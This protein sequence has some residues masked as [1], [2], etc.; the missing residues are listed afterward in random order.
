MLILI[1]WLATFDPS[2]NVTH[3]LRFEAQ[4]LAPHEC[5]AMRDQIDRQIE[6][7]FARSDLPRAEL[8]GHEGD[9]DWRLIGVDCEPSSARSTDAIASLVTERA[10][11]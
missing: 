8:Y 10:A 11:L 6:A 2:D 4:T 1:L 7:G 5:K 9:G 3:M